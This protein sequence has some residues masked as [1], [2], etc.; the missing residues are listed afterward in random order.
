M[1]LEMTYH[2]SLFESCSPRVTN[3]DELPHFGH[4]FA[5]SGTRTAS[6]DMMSL[7]HPDLSPRSL[8]RQRVASARQLHAS[9]SL[10]APDHFLAGLIPLPHSAVVCVTSGLGACVRVWASKF[11]FQFKL[12]CPAEDHRHIGGS[13]RIKSDRTSH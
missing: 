6:T 1:F 3:T 2:R 5:Q 13:R 7:L 9:F 11:L 8:S 12:P 10:P 4:L